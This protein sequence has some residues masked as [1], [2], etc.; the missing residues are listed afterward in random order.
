MKNPNADQNVGA[1]RHLKALAVEMWR[2]EGGHSSNSA[3]EERNMYYPD[4][5]CDDNWDTG[6]TS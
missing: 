2:A 3:L 5:I 1:R 4:V 6:G